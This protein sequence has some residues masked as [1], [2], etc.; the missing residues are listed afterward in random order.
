LVSR[1][2]NSSSM[3]LVLLLDVVEEPLDELA[4]AA[5]LAF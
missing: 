1:A 4:L 5:W 3:E 2:L